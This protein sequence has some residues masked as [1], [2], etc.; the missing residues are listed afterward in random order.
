MLSFGFIN[1]FV[2][3]FH[4]VN[5]NSYIR[6]LHAS[7]NA[8]AVDIYAN[9]I[10]IAR[11]LSYR[12]FSNYL[13]VPPGRY[14]VRIYPAGQKINPVLNTSITV[15]ERSIQTAAAIGLV[16]Q[17]SLQVVNDPVIPTVP[18]RVLVRFVHFSPNAPS[19]DITLSGGSPVF[20][21]VEYREVTDYV[22]INPGTYTLY[23]RIAGT[24]QQILYVPNITLKADR[25]YT[26]YAV[27][28][29]GG[30]PPLQALIP[31]DGNS[32]IKF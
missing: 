20:Q 6:V 12:G 1:P 7:P 28:I 11:N 15:P 10:L 27:G 23:A 19:V 32:Y 26:V 25:F 2:P 14:N 24:G 22:P 8:P 31:L 30:N 9:D 4:R 29:A 17:L 3:A 13:P 16:P 21:D 18:G 5:M